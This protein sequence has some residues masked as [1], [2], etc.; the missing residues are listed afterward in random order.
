MGD[1]PCPRCL[2]PL[3]DAHRI[4]TALDRK[5][6]KLLARVDDLQYRVK[7]SSA[8]K[9]IYEDNRGV[10]SV[11]VERWLKEESLVPT[12]VCLFFPAVPSVF[13]DNF[14]L[15]FPRDCHALVLISLAFFWLTLCMNS[16][17]E[18]GKRFSFTFSEFLPVFL[19]LQTK[20]MKGKLSIY[21]GIS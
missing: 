13:S 20:W 10:N 19:E 11:F 14:R 17:L 5:Q 4:G 9:V 3:Y 21:S 15:H 16:S 1:C 7:I 18:F 2:T 8:H 12:E 6:R